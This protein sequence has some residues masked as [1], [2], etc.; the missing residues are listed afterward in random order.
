[1]AITWRLRNHKSLLFIVKNVYL[2][3]TMDASLLY[4]VIYCQMTSESKGHFGPELPRLYYL[5]K[6]AA[7][8]KFSAR[9]CGVCH[10]QRTNPNHSYRCAPA[11]AFVA[12]STTVAPKSASLVTKRLPRAVQDAFTVVINP[13]NLTVVIFGCA[14]LPAVCTL[15]ADVCCV[16]VVNNSDKPIEILAGYPVASVYIVRPV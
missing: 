13:L 9:V 7:L 15:I 2:G 1:M 5:L 3:Q 6:S 14:A 10:E 8:L 12:E 4:I 16:A 11:V